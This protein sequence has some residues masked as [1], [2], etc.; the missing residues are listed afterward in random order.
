MRY[1]DITLVGEDA[2]RRVFNVFMK[3]GDVWCPWEVGPSKE[4]R[5][6]SNPVTSDLSPHMRHFFCKFELMYLILYNG[7]R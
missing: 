4:G 6:G 5:T 3:Y 7:F 1:Y 2:L